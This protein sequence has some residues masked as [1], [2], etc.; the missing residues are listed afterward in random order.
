MRKAATQPTNN[1]QKKL[2]KKT[3][4]LIPYSSCLPGDTQEEKCNAQP[5]GV[6]PLFL[7]IP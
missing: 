7:N 3:D 5:T 6:A 1:F 4:E 2:R